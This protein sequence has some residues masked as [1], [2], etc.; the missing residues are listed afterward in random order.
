MIRRKQRNFLISLVFAAF[1]V[2]VLHAVTSFLN[3]NVLYLVFILL[4]IILSLTVVAPVF[5][6]RTIFVVLKLPLVHEFLKVEN[7]EITYRV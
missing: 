3:L 6:L 1:I 5:R 2:I 7:V 4:V